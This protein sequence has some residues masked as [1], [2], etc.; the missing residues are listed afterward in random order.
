ML[1]T[2]GAYVRNI[3]NSRLEEF[4]ERVNLYGRSNFKMRTI[5]YAVCYD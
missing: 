2:F 1:E 5:E 3:P 4:L